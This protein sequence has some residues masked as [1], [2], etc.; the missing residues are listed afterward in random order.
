MEAVTTE[1][2]TIKQ[3][4]VCAACGNYTELTRTLELPGDLRVLI[5]EYCYCPS[6]GYNYNRRNWE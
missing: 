5:C 3:Y 2:A 4:G 1:T 6:E